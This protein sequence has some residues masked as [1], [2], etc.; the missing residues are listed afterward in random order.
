MI[1]YYEQV[2]FTQTIFFITGDWVDG[3]E[4]EQATLAEFCEE[5]AEETTTPMGVG[6]L[7]HVRD[8]ELR[9]WSIS[10]DSSI[11]ETFE[12]NEQAIH[13]L[14]ISFLYDATHDDSAPSI[15]YSENEAQ[16]ALKEIIESQSD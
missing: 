9:Q 13:A 11:V 14:Y 15:Y 4:I 3:F 12:T 8:N 5:H 6:S 16:E 10:G 7:M 1:N 2:D